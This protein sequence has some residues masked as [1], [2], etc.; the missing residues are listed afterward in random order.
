M[1]KVIVPVI[2]V[3]TLLVLGILFGVIPTGSLLDDG[4]DTK[5]IEKAGCTGNPSSELLDQKAYI[6]SYKDDGFSE[7]IVV[8][9]TIKRGSWS[10]AHVLK[11]KY[12]V[13]LK[14]NEWSTYETVSKPGE[15]SKYLSNPN[16]GNM[17]SNWDGG[18]GAGEIYQV[19]PY[20]FRIVGDKYSDGAIKVELYA[21]HDWNQLDPFDGYNWRLFSSDEAML[22]SGYGGLYLPRGVEDGEDRPYNT[23]EIGQEVDIR[24]ETA[25]GGYGETD[26]P[27]RVTL[28]E[29]YNTDWE[30]WDDPD[31][32]GG[33]IVEKY[34]KNDVTNGHF[35]F[36]VTEE[37]AK[38]SMQSSD[39][40]TIRIWNVLLPKG[41]LYVDFLDFI[42][43]A[44][45]DVEFTIS[46][47]QIK[48]GEKCSVGLSA[49][50]D[51]GIDCFRVS[52]IYGTND[53][54]LPSDP[55][56]KLWIINT[57]NIGNKDGKTCS[58][59]QTIEFI[60]EYSSYVTVHAKAI[61]IEGRASV[62]TRTYT[63]W[64]YK[65]NPVPDDTIDDETG[66]EDYGGGQTPG[67]MPWDPEGGNWEGTNGE[68][69]EINWLGAL[70]SVL[71]V[72]GMILAGFL[73]F[74]QPRMIIIMGIAGIIIAILTYAVFFTDL[75]L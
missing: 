12:I 66:D 73:I 4:L 60:P 43:L 46:D 14:E 67:A 49:E 45:S 1:L 51:L 47:I 40:Y 19:P 57:N 23:F 55:L 42:A 58:I 7:K 71:I 30:D 50:S 16:P 31:E 11:Y 21:Y 6:L 48:V 70:I 24:V 62:R 27:W 34:Y 59:P 52:V 61:D 74:K 32:G 41:S 69:I 64:A 36:T 20:N 75:F 5:S 38:K 22:Y 2:G 33:V 68:P 25:K 13:Y 3:V 8:S 54:L 65:V 63:V 17:V 37:M 28:N 18:E 53:V 26:K 9:G 44:P 39:P 29:P 10:M 56:S 15:T 72:V 35:K